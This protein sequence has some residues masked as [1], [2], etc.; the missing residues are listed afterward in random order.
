MQEQKAEEQVI[1]LGNAVPRRGFRTFIFG[2]E[3]KQKLVESWEEFDL[4]THSDSWF[5]TKEE[6]EA[7]KK[8]RKKTES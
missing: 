6:A 8:P 5:A 1:Y 7:H 4:Y 2:L 3:G